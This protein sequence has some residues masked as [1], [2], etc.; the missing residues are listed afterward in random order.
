MDKIV[1][2]FIE[3]F[4]KANS[5]IWIVIKIHLLGRDP[6]LW[7][8]HVHHLHVLDAGQ[9]EMKPRAQGATFLEAA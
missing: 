2:S 7:C 4:P 8:P 3:I 9:L 5:N 1:W 6:H